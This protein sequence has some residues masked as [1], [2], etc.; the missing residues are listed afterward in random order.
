ME[1]VSHREIYDRLV[2]VES[3]VDKIGEDTKDVVTAFNSAKGAFLVLDWIGKL[4]KPILWLVGLSTIIVTAY[5]RF[6]K[7]IH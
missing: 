3:K 7:S 6:Q 4:T 2:A 5:E 1:D